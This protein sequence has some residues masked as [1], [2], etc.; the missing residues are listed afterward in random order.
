MAIHSSTAYRIPEQKSLVGYSPRW[1]TSL[2]FIES[3]YSLRLLWVLCSSLKYLFTY[4]AASGLS[5][6][7]WD[8]LLRCTDSI[9]SP[10]AQ[11]LWYKG[12]VPL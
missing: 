7:T 2:H 11:Q 4:L 1:S 5:C 8:L 3:M 12:L 10:G 6:G 9:C